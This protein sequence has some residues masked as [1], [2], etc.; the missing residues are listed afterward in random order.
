[1]EIAKKRSFDFLGKRKIAFVVSAV[2]VILGLVAAVSIPL[3]KANLGTDFSGGVSVQ[4]RFEKHVSIDSVRDFLKGGGFSDANL[5]E[6]SGSNS[7]LVRVKRSGDLSGVADSIGEVFKKNMPDNPFQVE[8]KAEVGPAVGKKLQKDALWA[9]AISLLGILLYVAWRFEFRFGVAAVAATFHDVLAILGVLFV[10]NKEINLLI[11]TALLT[12]AGYSLTDTVVVFDRIR[13]NMRKHTKEGFSS[14]INRSVNEVLT[15][16]MITSGTTL[17]S[18]VAL[19]I[20]G[21]A[22]IRDFSL[23]LF[24]GIIVGTYSSIFIA[25]PLLLLWKGKK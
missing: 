24:L 4:F 1:M 2:L 9:V 8:L 20:L 7:L 6:F 17:L 5:Q 18:L 14:L 22:V 3:G 16:T 10:L 15:R 25:S 12:L 13:E 23:A 11:I 21:G 19:L